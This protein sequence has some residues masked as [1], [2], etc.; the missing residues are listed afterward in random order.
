MCLPYVNRAVPVR[1][2]LHSPRPACLGTAQ[3]VDVRCVSAVCHRVILIVV[4]YGLR[5]FLPACLH[6]AE[7]REHAAKV[8]TM[9]RRREDVRDSFLDMVDAENE[10]AIQAL[11]TPLEVSTPSKPTFLTEDFSRFLNILPTTAFETASIAAPESERA[12]PS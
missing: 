8:Q 4:H 6:A 12:F 9:D 11:E 2:R 10:T 3:G 5:A 7:Q 1:A